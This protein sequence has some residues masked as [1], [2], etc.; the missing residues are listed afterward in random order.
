[1]RCRTLLLLRKQGAPR[2]TTELRKWLDERKASQITRRQSA[3]EMGVSVDSLRRWERKGAP[4][5]DVN[6]CKL[7]RSAEGSRRRARHSEA[8]AQRCIDR[9]LRARLRSLLIQPQND[10]ARLW[11]LVGCSREQLRVHLE[12]QFCGHMSWENRHRWHIDHIRPCASFDLTDPD[13]VRQCFHFSNLR[14]IWAEDNM[15]R[16]KRWQS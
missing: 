6:S 7:W 16:G 12:R 9:R 1:M 10:S 3:Q 8:V 2:T 14:P 13:Q 4:I 5:L 11:E 15:I